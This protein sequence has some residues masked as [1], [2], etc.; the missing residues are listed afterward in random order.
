MR[1][2]QF[3]AD[4]FRFS[5]KN[6]HRVAHRMLWNFPPAPKG[7]NTTPSAKILKT[8]YFIDILSFLPTYLAALDMTRGRDW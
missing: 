7:S 4:V 6:G 3:R 2:T 5:P 1:N 8:P